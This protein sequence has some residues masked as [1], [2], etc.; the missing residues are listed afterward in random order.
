MKPK[1]FD[2]EDI[3]NKVFELFWRHG[4][5]G[6]SLQMLEQATGLRRSSIYHSFSSKH[7]LFRKALTQYIKKVAGEY[8]TCFAESP[9]FIDGLERLLNQMMDACRQ[10]SGCLLVL[11]SL[12]M[13]QHEPETQELI[14]YAHAMMRETLFKRLQLAQK[15]G[16]IAA[17][18]NILALAETLYIF[19]NG[20]LVANKVTFLPCDE[21]IGKIKALLNA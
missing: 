16:E 7:A 14:R 4:F 13:E 21:A 17:D 2:E 9:T 10:P 1:L 12:E 5:D 6:T 11:S 20:A 19:I 18:R 8:Q 15:N 3:L